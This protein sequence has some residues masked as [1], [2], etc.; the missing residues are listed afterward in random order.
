M[1]GWPG[2]LT[3]RTRRRFGQGLVVGLLPFQFGELRQPYLNTAVFPGR[4]GAHGQHF[5]GARNNV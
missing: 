3:L 4:T 5:F 2:L 1:I